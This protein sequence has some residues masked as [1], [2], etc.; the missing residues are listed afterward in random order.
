MCTIAAALLLAYALKEGLASSFD[1]LPAAEAARAAL[2]DDTTFKSAEA[3]CRASGGFDDTS[4]QMARGWL[5]WAA[6][7]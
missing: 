2:K 3:A 1:P 6:K 4:I 7:Q 5:E